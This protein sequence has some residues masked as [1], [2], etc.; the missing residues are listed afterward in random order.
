MS[1]SN[2]TEVFNDLEN[3]FKPDAAATLEAIFQFHITDAGDDQAADWLVRID[4][5]QCQV[6]P[7]TADE[8]T[9]TLKLSEQTWVELGKGEKGAIGAFMSGQ[10]QAG[11]NVMLAQ[12]LGPVFGFTL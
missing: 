12:K 9:V 2:A 11:G 7:G 6:E 5:G 8:P 10:I 1:Y 3:R 4:N